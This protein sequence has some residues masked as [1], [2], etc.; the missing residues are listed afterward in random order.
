MITSTITQQVISQLD[1]LPFELQL[2]VLDYTQSLVF[3]LPKG[4]HGE[5]LLRFVGVIESGDIQAM[6][7]A[8]KAEC[9]KVDASEW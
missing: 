2:R 3:S 1:R 7:Q 4:V 6:S 9:E 8:I 5:Q